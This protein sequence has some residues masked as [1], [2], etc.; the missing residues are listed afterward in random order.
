MRNLLLLFVFSVLAASIN[1][2]FFL[3]FISSDKAVNRGLIQ[4]V[5]SFHGAKT[6]ARR[7]NVTPSLSDKAFRSQQGEDKFLLQNYFKHV[8]EGTY[9][10]MGGLDGHTFINS[11]FFNQVMDW[12]GVLIEADPENY[13]KLIKNRKNELVPPIHAAVCDEESDVHWVSSSVRAV[14]GILEFTPKTFRDKWWGDL[15]N[16]PLSQVI[17]N[18]KVGNDNNAFF[19]FFSLDVE[20]MLNVFYFHSFS[21]ARN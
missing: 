13:K 1:F 17:R 20:G 10:E 4:E 14:R 15:V 19:D 3:K 11:W 2:I 5:S 12:K 21:T 6:Q 8:C 9:I 7:C 18:A 16:M